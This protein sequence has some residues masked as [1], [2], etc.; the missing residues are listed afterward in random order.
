MANKNPQQKDSDLVSIGRSLSD[1]FSEV[2]E[3]IR[4][5]AYQLFLDRDSGQGNPVSD[6]LEAQAEFVTPVELVLKEQKKNIVVEG[7]L[8][9]FS[10]QEIEIDVGG[11]ELRVFGSH[12]QTEKNRQSGTSQSSSQSAYFYQAL[13]LPCAID[14]DKC[15][16]TL[17]K[18]GKLKITLPKSPEAK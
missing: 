18:N 4:E 5:R 3:Q 7:D 16:A 12:T 10:P 2:Q 6:W 14:A 1:A 13:S 15:T 9:G 11:D 8:K 17:L